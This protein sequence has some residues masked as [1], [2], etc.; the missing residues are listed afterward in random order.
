[1]NNIQSRI[2]QLTNRI[3]VLEQKINDSGSNQA[4]QLSEEVLVNDTALINKTPIIAF[5][6]QGS[7]KK[8]KK[9]K[10]SKKSSSKKKKKSS[11]GKGTKRKTRKKTRRY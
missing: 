3:D 2:S 7:S 10:S 11:G 9:K 6:D 8:K 1:M 4:T 5:D